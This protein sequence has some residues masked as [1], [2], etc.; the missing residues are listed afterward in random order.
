MVDRAHPLHRPVGDPLRERAV[1]RVELAGR[2]RERAVGVGVVLEDAPHDLE[3]D[4][5]RRRDHG[6]TPRRNSS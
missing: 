3:R 1:A 4:A 5:T 6:C 2:R